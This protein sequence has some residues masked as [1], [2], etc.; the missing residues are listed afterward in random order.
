LIPTQNFSYSNALEL[1]HD[2]NV[3]SEFEKLAEIYDFSRA[4]KISMAS[5]LQHDPINY[6][7]D[8]LPIKLKKISEPKN[9]T[10]N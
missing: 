5:L 4:F 2:C 7:K 6:I 8:I 9:I 3:K 10:D 1:I